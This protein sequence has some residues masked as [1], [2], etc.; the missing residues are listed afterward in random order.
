LAPVELVLAL[1]VWM[2]LASAMVIVGNLGAWKI[3][4]HAAV[5]EAAM[6]SQWP[7][8]RTADVAPREWNRP[9]AGLQLIAG[10]P[11][12]SAD[13]LRDHAVIR[14][15]QLSSPG[16]VVPIGVDAMVME[17]RSQALAGEAFLNE[18]PPLWPRSRVRMRYHREFPIVDANCGAWLSGQSGQLRSSTIWNLPLVE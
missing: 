16:S 2:L 3:R 1:P 9:S 7:R 10:S 11:V 13:P 14:G 5:R 4:G 6:R 15:P 8:T 17:P 18:P 12:S